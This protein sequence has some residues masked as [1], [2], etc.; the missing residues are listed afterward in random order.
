MATLTTEQTIAAQILAMDSGEFDL[1]GQTL[2]AM[3]LISKMKAK[4]FDPGKRMT[5]GNG[6]LIGLEVAGV[7]NLDFDASVTFLQGGRSGYAVQTGSAYAGAGVPTIPCRSI[8]F[9]GCKVRGYPDKPMIEQAGTAMFLR[10]TL[11]WSVTEVDFDHAN[12]MFTA[13]GGNGGL[14]ARNHLQNMHEDAIHVV[15][16]DNVV[17]EDNDA[18]DWDTAVPDGVAAIHPDAVQ[19]WIEKGQQITSLIVRGNRF[20]RGGGD[21]MQGIFVRY[22]DPVTTRRAQ[23]SGL[24]IERNVIAGGMWNG[25]VVTG[26]GAVNDNAVLTTPWDAISGL[27]SR[28]VSTHWRGSMSGNSA[29]RFINQDVSGFAA[30]TVVPAGNSLNTVMTEAEAMAI[31]SAWRAP[32]APKLEDFFPADQAAILRKTFAPLAQSAA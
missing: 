1:G 13:Y 20:W 26:D 29:A 27:E 10:D 11:D 32:P 25:I 18:H 7:E 30:Q 4:A 8:G 19:V 15:G 24:L 3:Q 9:K 21:V 22:Y 28:I 2:T 12:S 31:V 17:V 16:C 23:P 14:F 6:T 5:I